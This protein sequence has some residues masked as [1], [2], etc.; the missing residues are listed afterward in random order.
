MMNNYYLDNE[1]IL[2]EMYSNINTLL[3]KRNIKHEIKIR[4]K[5][6]IAIIIANFIILNNACFFISF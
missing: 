4:T 2:K 6:I 3:N 5:N 1:D